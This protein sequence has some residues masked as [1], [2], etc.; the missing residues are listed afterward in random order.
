MPVACPQGVDFV[1][2]SIATDLSGAT[3]RL[4]S[5]TSPDGIT[6]TKDFDGEDE[7]TALLCPGGEDAMDAVHLTEPC[8]I[9]LEGG[10]FRLYWESCDRHGAWRILSATAAA[11]P[12][13]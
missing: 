2:Q 10:G 5:A 8:L 4:F 9:E 6:W 3:A 11:R 7:A 13:L 12:S 1:R